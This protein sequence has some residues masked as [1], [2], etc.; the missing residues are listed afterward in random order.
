GAGGGQE[1]RQAARVGAGAGE[2]VV[3]RLLAHERRE[4]QWVHPAALALRLQPVWLGDRVGQALQRARDRQQR[5]LG[6]G[7]DRR[8]RRARREV[9]GAAVG[10]ELGQRE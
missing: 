3:G 8:L 6:G 10:Q 7:V 2:R 4:Q 1:L 9:V 5:A